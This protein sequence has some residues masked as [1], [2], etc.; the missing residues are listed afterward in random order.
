MKKLDEIDLVSEEDLNSH[1]LLDVK[2]FSTD[3]L[4][5]FLV[6]NQSRGR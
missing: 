3:G 2:N 6:I 5:K 4:L 1:D